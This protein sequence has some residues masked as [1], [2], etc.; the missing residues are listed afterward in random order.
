MGLHLWDTA[1][2][3]RFERSFPKDY[4]RNS[5]VAL[6]VY[7]ITS[8]DSIKNSR[9]YNLCAGIY[10]LNNNLFYC[11]TGDFLRSRQVGWLCKRRM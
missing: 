5:A 7:D 6:V 1:G 8:M 3:E 11:R 2:Q 10:S 9:I 4:I